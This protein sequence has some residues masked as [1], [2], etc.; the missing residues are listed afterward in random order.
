M[1][2]E[3]FSQIVQGLLPS[4]I[5]KHL[6]VGVS[7]G[8]DSLFLTLH[9][10]AWAAQHK[11]TVTPFIVDHGIRSNSRT[12]ALAVAQWLINWGMHPQI[13]EGAALSGPGGLPEKARALRYALLSAACHAANIQYLFLGHQQDDVLETVLM[14]QHNASGWRGLA[15]ISPKTQRF[16]I[17]WVRP[18]LGVPR[19]HLQAWLRDNQIPWVDDPTNT[20]LR[21]TRPQVREQLSQLS[22]LMRQR[23]WRNT[24][25]YGQR[26]EQENAWFSMMCTPVLSPLGYLVIPFSTLALLSQDH[27]AWMLGHWIGSLR[28]QRSPL[29]R[30]AL[31]RGWQAVQSLL[32]RPPVKTPKILYTLGGCVWASQGDRM[33]I[34][35]E[36]TRHGGASLLQGTQIDG[37]TGHQTALP[38]WWD[39]RFLVQSL[40]FLNP[41]LAAIS[42]HPLHT[43]FKDLP[44]WLQPLCSA[45]FPPNFPSPQVHLIPCGPPL[46]MFQGVG[47]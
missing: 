13:L 32:G 40:A 38:I 19:S 46:P 9:L 47:L 31:Q 42:P 35:P 20:D 44:P 5:P 28:Y 15:G 23:L 21:F 1:T 37:K 22:G 29:K 2:Y 45:T 30:P 3:E 16:G 6:G 8:S 11:V 43:L 4:P 33:F 18:L 27:G 14:R 7:G 41:A 26:R 17:T 24:L 10:F 39:H 34:F 36:Q 25:E 12:E